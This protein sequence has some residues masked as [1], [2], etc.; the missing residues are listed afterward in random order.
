MADSGAHAMDM[1]IEQLRRFMD[2]FTSTLDG[3]VEGVSL[4]VRD[5]VAEYLSQYNELVPACNARLHSASALLS[6]GLRD[7]A[8]GYESDEPALLEA[9][10]LLD[11]SGRPR[12]NAWLDALAANGIPE[13]GLPKIEHAVELRAAQDKVAELKPLLDRW[14]RENLSGASLAARMKT[15]RKLREADSD[16]E[17]WYSCLVACERQ[18][19]MDIEADLKAAVASSDEERLQSIVEEFESPWVEKPPARIEKTARQALASLRGS[20]VDRELSEVSGGL[21]AAMEHK[22]LESARALRD[23]W[24]RLVDAKG[25]FAIDDANVLRAEPAVSWLER[26]ERLEI[27]FAEVWHS[28]EAR[29]SLRLERAEWARSLARMRDEVED[30]S[31][32][33]ADEIDLEPVERLR[34]R[35]ARVELELE[36]EVGHRRRLMLLSTVGTVA[37]VG[38]L[39][40]ASLTYIRR[41]D[42]VRK[43]A[44]EL[45]GLEERAAAGE[46]IGDTVAA[47]EKIWPA[48]LAADPIV[49]SRL[50]QCRATLAAEDTRRERLASFDR[51]VTPVLENLAKAVPPAEMGPWPQDFAEASRL[52][53]SA[54]TGALAKN[55]S[56]KSLVAKARGRLEAAAKRLERAGD[57]AFAVKANAINARLAELRDMA[58]ADPAEV[59]GAL[60]E[61]ERSITDLRAAANERAVA[62]AAAPF[63]SQ[64]R[65]NR[66]VAKQ[67]EEGGPLMTS[68][69]ELRSRV[70]LLGRFAGQEAKLDDSL[71]DWEAY[72]AKLKAIAK[73]FETLPESR[74]YGEAASIERLW[75]GIGEWSRFAAATPSIGSLDADGAKALKKS[76]AGLSPEAQKLDVSSAFRERVGPVLDSMAERDLDAVGRDLQAWCQREWLTEVPWLITEDDPDGPL[77]YYAR[78]QP[79]PGRSFKYQRE[80]KQPG[81]WPP[82]K[83]KE[84]SVEFR[85]TASPQKQ[86]GDEWLALAARIN[87]AS[88]GLDADEALA[89]V[90][91]LVMRAEKVEPCVRLV[92][93]RKILMAGKK[94]SGAFQT[95]KVN[96][97]IAS[98]DDGSGGIPGITISDLSEYLD[99]KR[100]TNPK[101]L[102]VKQNA[103]Q[104]LDRAIPVAQAIIRE[105]G[106]ASTR[107]DDLRIDTYE[108]VGRVSRGSDG[109]LRLIPRTGGQQPTKVVDVVVLK[110]DGKESV[111]GRTDG[112]GGLDIAKGTSTPAGTPCFVRRPKAVSGRPQSSKSKTAAGDASP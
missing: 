19:L 51:D 85:S 14:R 73:E 94:V 78:D 82:P 10:T 57:E 109:T 71:G 11:L 24:N 12:Y 41:S 62:G 104:H 16:N 106:Q 99:P 110:A 42:Q 96:A 100:A 30:L 37:A 9:V 45:A 83:T 70:D 79:R 23:R 80:M 43:V 102:R 111:I 50:G 25:T 65:V 101:Y 39:A 32:K 8:L 3:L 48:W 58:A 4:S 91:D 34:D 64:M 33:L 15:L 66:G 98:I 26:H 88:K 56:E 18:R 44:A 77:E 35:V 95:D 60:A 59:R 68:V 87:N 20:R 40:F 52:I 69:S 108:C 27:L 1:S 107:I 46:L 84:T 7:E 2:R 13:P 76:I 63:D 21:A 53:A 36:R 103:E 67:V 17:S 93:L 49:K 61:V 72:A 22:D 38:A 6:R 81:G 29:P 74:D 90:V 54:D 47:T 105:V 31:E 55:E 97:F 112:K 5:E 75:A 89:S 92:N 86:L 28:L